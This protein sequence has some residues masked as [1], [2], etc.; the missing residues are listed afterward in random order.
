MRTN[1]SS[2]L[3]YLAILQKKHDVI[4]MQE[5]GLEFHFHETLQLTFVLQIPFLNAKAYLYLEAGSL[6]LVAVR[7]VFCLGQPT[8]TVSKMKTAVCRLAN[9]GQIRLYSYGAE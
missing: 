4:S 5:P 2:N 6:G 3:G 7:G 9:L 8:V 1:V